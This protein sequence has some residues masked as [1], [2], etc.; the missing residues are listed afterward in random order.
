MFLEVFTILCLGIIA[1]LMLPKIPNK[2]TRMF[3]GIIF[4]TFLSTAF[5]YASEGAVTEPPVWLADLLVFIGSIPT[6]G[7]IV[8]E[9]FKWLGVI[10]SVFTA[11]SVALSVIVKIPELA[12]RF[13]GLEK[14]AD[15]LKKINDT[16]QPYLKYLSIFNVPKK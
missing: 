8:V 5:A 6:V 1:F 13:A 2:N 12:A 15:T 16:I 10:A 3:V 7:P 14:V 11:L 4:T 9:V